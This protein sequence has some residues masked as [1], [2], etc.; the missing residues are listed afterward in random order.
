MLISQ[1]HINARGIPD[2]IQ[3]VLVKPPWHEGATLPD[4]RAQAGAPAG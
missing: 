4:A 1:I 3:T 2:P